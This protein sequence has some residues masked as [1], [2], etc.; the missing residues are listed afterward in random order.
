VDAN[1]KWGGCKSVEKLYQA[2]C[3]AFYVTFSFPE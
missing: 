1:E 3:G 2:E